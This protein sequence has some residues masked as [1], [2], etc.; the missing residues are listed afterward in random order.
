LTLTDEIFDYIVSELE[1]K[2]GTE[3]ANFQPKFLID[4][5]A[6]ACGFKETPPQFTR[7][8]IDYAI[9]NLS[10]SKSKTQ[11]ATLAKV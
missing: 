3:L 11:R 1:E 8:L 2:R 7:Q 10:V 4:Q 6:A 9:S 5:I